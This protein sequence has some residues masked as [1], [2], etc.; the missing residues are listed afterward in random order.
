MASAIAA[1][2]TVLVAP[3]VARASLGEMNLGTF[4]NDFGTKNEG[5]T[6]REQH[7]NQEMTKGNIKTPSQATGSPMG[8]RFRTDLGRQKS[9]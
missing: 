4:W 5:K 9:S 6:N 2:V 7:R 3:Q 8:E 1:F